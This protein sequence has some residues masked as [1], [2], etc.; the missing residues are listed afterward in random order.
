MAFEVFVL[1]VEDFIISVVQ[2]IIEYREKHNLTRK[3]FFQLL[4]QLRNT[5]KIQK[6]DNFEVTP[7]SDHKFLSIRRF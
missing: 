2:E 6:G 7:A 4:L 3:D 5:C 1:E